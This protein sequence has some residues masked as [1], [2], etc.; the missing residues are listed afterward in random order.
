MRNVLQEAAPSAP[1]Q[2]VS[3][4]QKSTEPNYSSYSPQS[5][6]ANSA[7]TSPPCAPAQQ[8]HLPSASKDQPHPSPTLCP[9]ADPQSCPPARQYSSHA[10]PQSAAATPCASPGTPHSRS[11]TPLPLPRDE[12]RRPTPGNSSACET[13]CDASLLSPLSKHAESLRLPARSAPYRQ[14]AIPAVR[15]HPYCGA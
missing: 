13:A 15:S 5:P 2:T 14:S 8:P 12:S 6:P 10:A 1:P 9:P 11:G 7:P 4:A 3:P